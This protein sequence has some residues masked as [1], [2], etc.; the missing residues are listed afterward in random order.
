MKKALIV[1]YIIAGLA[2]FTLRS[3]LNIL[4][5]FTPQSG[6][7]TITLSENGFE[8]ESVT[9]EK[10]TVVTFQT[11]RGKHFWPASDLHPTHDIYPA[12]DPK[13]P[14]APDKTWS[15]RFDRVG[16]WKYHD[17]LAPYYTGEITVVEPGV[18]DEDDKSL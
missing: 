5:S 17:H 9:V 15:F 3:K 16:E 7:V 14:I 11:T 6:S 8:P 18:G 12:F 13:E 1:F 2:F 10:G 4:A